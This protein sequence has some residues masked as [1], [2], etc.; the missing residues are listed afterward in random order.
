MLVQFMILK[1]QLEGP[2]YTCDKLKNDEKI[3]QQIEEE[4][5]HFKKDLNE[6]KSGNSR[7]K[8]EKQLYRIKNIKNV[9]DARQKLFDLL[10][11]YSKIRSEA[12]YKSKQNETKGTG[13]KI[14]TSKQM[15]Q[16][17]AIALAQVKAGNN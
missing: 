2:M 10:N 5:K 13:F 17:S 12:M 3:L 8:S 4:Q 15:N 14:L 16:R 7:H 9:Y 6:I 11:D 1:V